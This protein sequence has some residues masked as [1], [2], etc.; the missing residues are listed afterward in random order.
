VSVWYKVASTADLPPEEI[1]RVH[2]G[3]ELIALYNCDGAYFATDDTCSHAEASLSDGWLEDCEVTC[4]LH[5]AIFDVKT[6]IPQCLPATR[7]IRTYVVRVE[8]D[9][10][11]VEV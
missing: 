3:D 10:I 5:G 8:G 7:P 6:G 1:K 4:P 2:A 11:F 9:D